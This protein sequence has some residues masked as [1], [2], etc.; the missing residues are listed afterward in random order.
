[1]AT[2]RQRKKPNIILLGIDSLRRDHMS[3]YGYERLTTPH[4][5]RFAQ[6]ATLFEETFSAHIPTTSAY[7]SMLTGR[8]VIGTQ[9]V[10][11]RHKGPLRPE[12][13]TLAEILKERRLQHDLCRFHRQP[14]FTRLRHLPGLLRLG[15]LELKDAAPRPRTST[16]WPLP[17]LDRLAKKR[18]PFFLFLRHWIPTRPICRRNRTSACS[19]TATSAIRRTSPWNRSWPS[20]PSAT[21]SPPGCRP[22]SATRTTS[23]P[24]TTGP[25]PTWTR[26]SRA[27]SQPSKRKGIADDTIVI[28]NGDHGE[29]LYDHEC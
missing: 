17:E 28:I 5:D 8:D 19:I 16:R 10:A 7:A 20:S 22:A 1:M 2:R 6:E 25:S 24:N 13:P 29:T 14:Q 21:S 9:V 23:S 12:V 3:C 11:L 15:K 27:S 18:D 4:I 26:P